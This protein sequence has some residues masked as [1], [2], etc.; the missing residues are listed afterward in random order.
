MS[1]PVTQ[2]PHVTR[3]SY[4]IPIPQLSNTAV[5]VPQS[6]YNMPTSNISESITT[7]KRTE[8]KPIV[9]TLIIDPVSSTGSRSELSKYNI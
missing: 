6:S 9:P 2:A 8:V 3:P 1:I 5:S 7:N 4:T